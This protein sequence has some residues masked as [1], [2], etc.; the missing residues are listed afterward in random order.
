[1]LNSSKNNFRAQNLGIRKFGGQ[2]SVLGD[3][4]HRFHGP[5]KKKTGLVKS[6]FVSFA[7]PF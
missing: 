3:W 4:E 5:Y 2:V 6:L 7:S 1:M